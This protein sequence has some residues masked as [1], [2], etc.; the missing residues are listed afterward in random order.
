MN[1]SPYQTKFGSVITI[2]I[3]CLIGVQIFLVGKEV[4]Y[5]LNPDVIFAKQLVAIPARF[6][7]TK[8]AFNFAF[9]VQF[10][11]NISQLIDES[12]YKV[13]AVQVTMQRKFNQTNQVFYQ[14]WN[15]LP[16]GIHRCSS[17]DFEVE[18]SINYFNTL[19]GLKNMYCLDYD[20]QNLYM[21]GSFDQDQYGSPE[22]INKILTN[23][24]VCHYTNDMIVNP[25]NVNPY[26]IISRDMYWSTNPIY[27][28][29]AYLYYRNIYVET[30]N[31]IVLEDI[32]T[33]RNPSLSS[34]QEQIIF[35]ESEY[36]F[37]MQLRF[38]EAKESIYHRKYKKLNSILAEI[39][40]IA[41]ALVM[42]GFIIC[43]PV[44]QRQLSYK[45]SNSLFKYSNH[46]NIQ[47]LQTVNA[48]PK[49]KYRKFSVNIFYV[50]H[51]SQ[52]VQQQTNV[53]N[54]Y[55]VKYTLLYKFTN[56]QSDTMSFLFLDMFGIGIS[57]R[58]MNKDKYQTCFGVGVTIIIDCILCVQIFFNG[59]EVILKTNPDVIYAERFVAS[60]AKFNITSKTFNL[61]FGAQFPG[62]HPCTSNDF[63]VENSID[64]FNKLAGIQNMYCLDYDSQ[65]LYIEGNFDQD[66]FGVIQIKF[67]KCQGQ[68]YCRDSDEIEQVLTNSQKA[69]YSN[70]VVLDP[71]NINPFSMIA[72]D[73]FWSTNPI[74]PKDATLYFQNIYF[75]SDNRIVFQDLEIQKQIQLSYTYEQEKVYHRHYQK[76]KTILAKIGGIAKALAMI[77]FIKCVPIN[78]LRLYNKLSNSV[79]KYPKTSNFKNEENQN[80]KQKI[81]EQT[82]IQVIEVQKEQNSKLGVQRIQ[83]HHQIQTLKQFEDL[84][85]PLYNKKFT[86]TPQSIGQICKN[87][88]NQ[89]SSQNEKEIQISKDQFSQNNIDIHQRDEYSKQLFNLDNSKSQNNENLQLKWFDYISYYLW[90]FGSFAK[91]KNQIDY[92]VEK[93]Y[94]HLDIIYI[95]KKLLEFEKAKQVLLNDDQRKLIQF[96]PKPL[97]D[98]EEIEQ[99]KLQEKKMLQSQKKLQKLKLNQQKINSLNDL[100]IDENQRAQEA[101]QS[102]Q[103]IIRQQNLTK[104]EQKIIETLNDSIF[105]NICCNFECLQQR[106]NPQETKLINLQ[107]QLDQDNIFTISNQNINQLDSNQS[108]IPKIQNQQNDFQSCLSR[109]QD[110]SFD[111]QMPNKGRTAQDFASLMQI[112]I[113]VMKKSN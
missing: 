4:V 74:F 27:P 21:E 108:Q 17:K 111:K 39:S 109:S 22:E 24:F 46:Q 28:K 48:I 94:Q 104:I 98:V 76:L 40:G 12:I 96:F 113:Q 88:N 73:L 38:E 67:K 51:F 9:G 47:K 72:R 35:G 79:F 107:N 33:Q 32:S 16:I 56:S 71:K 54:I 34:T 50:E 99:E 61:A 101:F 70:D 15:N 55:L 10:P 69:L 13:S 75:E 78:Q 18:E 103:N 64:Y 85:Q 86:Q 89:K 36:F 19:F 5:K 66:Q 2:I 20:S 59:Q 84:N 53:N 7:I 91:K 52:R 30:D 8:K 6:N 87:L 68:P 65:N 102:L 80:P 49:K 26:S 41:K 45:L 14:E 97:I 60:P 81:D 110:T 37:Q 23:S 57:L 3:E 92:S 29:D 25:K 83:S 77:G 58:Y 42:I 82:I 112:K 95:V 105:K 62:I 43:V 90:P 106:E 100:Q 11:G 1:K 44:N 63:E 31:G 93:I